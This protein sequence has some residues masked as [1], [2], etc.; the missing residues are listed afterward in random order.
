MRFHADGLD[1]GRGGAAE[2]VGEA[3]REIPHA[4]GGASCHDRTERSSP[5]WSA[6]HG[7]KLHE[8]VLFSMLSRALAT[9]LCLATSGREHSEQH[10][11]H[12]QAKD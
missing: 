12:D 4:Y 9:E 11:S 6:I 10:N 1:T 7:C 8:A 5:R 2:F 3:A